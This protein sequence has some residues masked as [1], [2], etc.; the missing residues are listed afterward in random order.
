MKSSLKPSFIKIVS[1]SIIENRQGLQG[2]KT[3][4]DILLTNAWICFHIISFITFPLSNFWLSNTSCAYLCPFSSL[5]WA[6]AGMTCHYVICQHCTGVSCDILAWQGKS[7][8]CRLLKL[9]N[10]PFQVFGKS[11]THIRQFKLINNNGLDN[12]VLE[13]QVAFSG[14]IF[15]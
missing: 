1:I 9:Q 4:L 13:L 6:L 2:K 8:S 12:K 7:F 3:A 15:F 5:F 11:L 10:V 14:G